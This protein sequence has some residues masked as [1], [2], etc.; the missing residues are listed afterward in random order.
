[1]PLRLWY[2]RAVGTM[3]NSRIAAFE[4]FGKPREVIVP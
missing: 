2:G 4:D 1:M 3:G